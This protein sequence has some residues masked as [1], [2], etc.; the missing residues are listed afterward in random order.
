M[1]NVAKTLLFLA[2]NQIVIEKWAC[3]DLMIILFTIK[4]SYLNLFPEEFTFMMAVTYF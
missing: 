2:Q 1:T 4:H 3:E